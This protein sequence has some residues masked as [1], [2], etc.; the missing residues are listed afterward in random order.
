MLGA[1]LLVGAGRRL[2]RYA[3][4]VM[5]CA[6]CAGTGAL[7]LGALAATPSAGARPAE[8]LGGWRPHHGAGVGIVLVGDPVGLGLAALVS[9][10]VLASLAF[11]W[12][13]FDEPPLRHA[14]SFP[15][16]VLLFQAGMCGF[17]LTGD[18][19]NAFVFFEL[20]GVVAYA[21]T[22]YRVEEARAVHGALVFALVN[23]LGAYATL[24]GIGLLYA[25]TGELGFAP[26]G[27][28]LDARPHG[29]GGPD[30]LVIAA[31]VLVVTGLLVK[32]AAVPFHF[33][34]ADAHAVAPT[35]V[36]MLLSGVMV[37]LGLYGAAR[38]YWTVF[39]SPGG[40]PAPDA[41][42]VLLTLGI[43]TAVLGAVMCW[44]QRHL[45]RLLAYST[46]AHTGLFLIGL[47]VLTPEGIG[48]VALYV[49][50]HAGVKAA[51]FACVGI[52]L[53]H[54][55]SVDEHQLH[56]KGRELPLVGVL[57]GVGGLALAGLPPFG[58]ALGKAVIEEAAGGWATGLCVLVSAATGGAVLRAGARVFL[59]LGPRPAD[60]PE[61]TTGE[62]EEPET[63]GGRLSRIP[64]S[65]T[66]VPAV[67][68]LG[69]LA[70]G[71]VPGLRPAI[72]RAADTFADHTGYA[73]SVLDGHA[74][75]PAPTPPPHW[76]LTGVLW[77]LLA[78]A[79]AAALAVL[80]V[81]R[82]V[83]QEPARWTV[84]LRRLHSGHVGDYVAWL[85]VGV[86]LLAAL[87]L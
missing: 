41:H 37:E 10:L 16:L 18:L 27:R 4:E 58:T 15:G 2:P 31:F 36:C 86:T 48:G 7:A 45:K 68:L 29:S 12:R 64:E 8:W 56:G 54:F 44:L 53:D 21:L 9:V 13:Y 17:A 14:G 72:G 5:G 6:I 85:L 46:V 66:A 50:A 82:A 39:A 52:L 69:A 47:A 23:S 43:V 63:R 75:P 51:L 24:L 28:A 33:W 67:L 76:S 35:P 19:F 79:L 40:I 87:A 62:N 73:A 30:A 74:S 59:G 42:R 22:G 38:V 61:E 65:M 71:L 34:L 70:V 78:T 84:P 81:R 83:R 57:F 32:A 1:A 20:M 55:G 77:G 60:A 25:R 49:L 26:I 11:A 3:A 80:A